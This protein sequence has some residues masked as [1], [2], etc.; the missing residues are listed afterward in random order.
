L[1][2]IPSTSHSS[3]EIAPAEKQSIGD[4]KN[5]PD[6]IGKSLL[7]LYLDVQ[8]D[9]SLDLITAHDIIDNFE[10]QVKEQI[11]E[12]S[13]ITAHIETE[14]TE[15]VDMG[16]QKSASRSYMENIR[17]IALSVDRV[18]DCM[19]IG[20]VDI[21]GELHITLVIKIKSSP[22]KSITSIDEAHRLATTVQNLI[23]N[24]TGASRVV[25]HAEPA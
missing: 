8:V 18:V 13:N 14:T 7:H 15:N 23:V 2:T 19:D 3:S 6:A 25:V 21:N 1:S 16:T 24:E 22:E 17:R 11:P 9:S 20:V 12:I 10:K 5:R 4:L